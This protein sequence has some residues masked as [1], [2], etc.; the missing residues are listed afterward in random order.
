[1]Y[2]IIKQCNQ[3]KLKNVKKSNNKLIN[4]NVN[5]KNKKLHKQ[6]DLNT[7]FN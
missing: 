6:W 3:Y 5:K 2:I 4:K 1:M 7:I